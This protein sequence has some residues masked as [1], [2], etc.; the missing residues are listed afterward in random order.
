[1]KTKATT[2]EKITEEK[3]INI[4]QDTSICLDLILFRIQQ[5]Y[6]MEVDIKALSVAEINALSDRPEVLEFEQKFKKLQSLI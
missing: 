1:M 5:L 2:V 3:V 4:I 6:D